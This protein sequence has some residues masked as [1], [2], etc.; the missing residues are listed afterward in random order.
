[1]CCTNRDSI[2]STSCLCGINKDQIWKGTHLDGFSPVP[3]VTWTGNLYILIHI[4]WSHDP[5]WFVC[6]SFARRAYHTLHTNVT[7]RRVLQL[8]H[9]VASH[10]GIPSGFYL[11]ASLFFNVPITYTPITKLLFL[12]VSWQ[13]CQWTFYSIG[14]YFCYNVVEDKVLTEHFSCY[15]KYLYDAYL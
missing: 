15:Y 8:F 9:T 1:M 13:D 12:S 10:A 2:Q 4:R 14:L 6:R 3:C 11:Q 5:V 7:R